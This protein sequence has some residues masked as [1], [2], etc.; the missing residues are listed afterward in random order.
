MESGWGTGS[1]WRGS[2]EVLADRE[3]LGKPG[4]R[5]AGAVHNDARLPSQNR[6]TQEAEHTAHTGGGGSDP[7]CAQGSRHLAT[8]PL[9]ASET[10]PLL[11]PW[12]PRSPSALSHVQVAYVVFALAVLEAPAGRLRDR[13][14]AGGQTPGATACPSSLQLP[15]PAPARQQ[16]N[17]KA[18]STHIPVASEAR[19]VTASPPWRP[20]AEPGKAAAPPNTLEFQRSLPNHAAKTP[21]K[22]GNTGATD[23]AQY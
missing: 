10:P 16:S 3:G 15:S 11:L 22:A 5:L 14:W 19:T 6:C 7:P 23:T 21:R 9:N 18:S 12:C 13:R 8:L 2:Y 1:I 17:N 4:G 20:A